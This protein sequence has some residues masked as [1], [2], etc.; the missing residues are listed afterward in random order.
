MSY[1]VEIIVTD[2][3]DTSPAAGTGPTQRLPMLYDTIEEAREAGIAFL[4]RNEAPPG[5]VTFQIVDEGGDLVVAP[6]AGSGPGS[7]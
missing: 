4:A 7:P 3:P 1:A 5:T 2:P 6:S